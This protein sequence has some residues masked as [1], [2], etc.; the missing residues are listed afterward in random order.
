MRGAPSIIV[1]GMQ[2]RFARA[3]LGVCLLHV[4]AGVVGVAGVARADPPGSASRIDHVHHDKK[5]HDPC[6]PYSRCP[7][8]PLPYAGTGYP[9]TYNYSG[10]FPDGFVWGLGTAAY[11]I[12]GA[13]KEGGRG[14][15]I[16]DTFTGADTVGMPGSVCDAT[17]CAV[18]PH[19]Y[20]VGATGN[21]AN[22]HY[23]NFKEDVALMQKLGLT[24]YRFSVSWPRLVPLGNAS[25]P[26]GV[27]PQG[28]A[29]YNALLD[30]LVAAGITPVVTLYHWDLPQQLLR[31]P[32]DTPSTQGWFARTPA[33]IVPLFA[34][35]ADLCFRL[36]SDRV[37]FWVTFNEAWTFTWLGGEAGKAPG[38]P[39][40]SESPKWPL[41]AGHNVLLAHA[42][43]VGIF[44]SKYSASGGKIGITNNVDW[45]EPRTTA[46]A[47]VTAAQRALEFQLAWFADPIYG[48]AG[49]YPSAMR[50]VLGDQLPSFTDEEKAALKGSADFF[51]LNSYGTGWAADT[52]E[53]GFCA[54]Y[55]AVD[56]AAGPDGPAFP[57][58]QSAWLYGSGWGLR[59]LVNW[60]ANRYGK[61]TTDIYVTE[62]GWSLAAGNVSV[63]VKDR[64]R[65][66]YYA[67]YTAA[68][69]DA[70]YVD[71]VRVKGYFAWSLMDNFEWERGFTE[72]F[73]V[74]FNNFQ[75]G[76]DP[77]APPGAFQKPTPTGQVRTPKESAKWLSQ[78]WAR[79]A[80]VDP[81][82]AG[83]V[84]TE[85]SACNTCAMCCHSWIPE[86]KDCAMCVREHCQP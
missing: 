24:H 84:C 14:A 43:A 36:F 10:A 23:H 16:W 20:A 29:F 58:A 31:P 59:K 2:L 11:Q 40:F 48:P 39:E 4:A 74:T 3:Q 86:G 66:Y 85:G 17:P 49:D 8:F 56:E 5:N 68:L 19:M 54:C 81:E 21:V 35:Y 18:N 15:S 41:I 26:A 50:T 30:A 70:I 60:I 1:P 69:R 6:W 79:N 80:L 72:R 63:A 34:A 47:D 73:G 53:A 32:Y 46:P 71:G 38:L 82:G 9:S 64:D 62:G 22:N 12:E 27:N 65:T 13:Y 83:S 25:D 55:C 67:N 7:A 78:V 52:D 57:K 76:E 45:K 51:G 37:K 75:F 33:P 77:D 28:V 61:D 42:A 44:R